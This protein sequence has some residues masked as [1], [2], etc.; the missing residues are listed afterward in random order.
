MKKQNRTKVICLLIMLILLTGCWDKRAID[1][2][3]HITVLG[4]DKS[5]EENRI[6]VTYLIT[7]P[8]FGTREGG[9]TNEPVREVISFTVDDFISAKDIANTILSREVTYDI[10][11]AIVVS[12]DFAKDENFIR[13]IYDTVKEAEIRGNTPLIV[14]KEAASKF[15]TDT[16][17]LV[18]T[19]EHRYFDLIID[20]GK[21]S[22]IIP[23]DSILLDFFRTV[24]SNAGLFLATFGTTELKTGDEQNPNG[25]DFIAGD[26]HVEGEINRTQF[27]GAA[28]FKEGKMIG[29]LTGR[30]TRVATFLNN[31]AE[32]SNLYTTF[33]DPFNK[34]YKIATRLTRKR[35]NQIKMDLKSN[36][37]TIKLKVFPIIDVLTNHSMVDYYHDK[38]KR[39]VLKKSIVDEETKRLKR[40]V[41]KTQ[42]EFKGD[43]FGWSL[44]ARRHFRTISEYEAFDWMKTYP[45]MKVDITVDV[46]FGEFGRQSKLPRLKE[47]R[48]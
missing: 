13:L 1:R 44:I 6:V 37:P 15:L 25:A 10:L 31:G 30:E 14:S 27:A 35:D 3:A 39:E 24:D 18:E 34:E 32:T 36:P 26:F 12:E 40:V 17:P 7:N 33:R 11:S 21:Q 45:N 46:E 5:E 38:E 22:D 48:D 29:E 8:E 28:V 41:K 16:R 4:L 9:A 47:V 42:E 20:L 19:R 43:P 23:N 2:K